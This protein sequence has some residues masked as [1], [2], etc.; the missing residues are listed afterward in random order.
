M[1]AVIDD[2]TFLQHASSSNAPL[3]FQFC[4]YFSYNHQNFGACGG[5]LRGRGC[6]QTRP[7]KLKMQKHFVVFQ[8]PM[9]VASAHMCK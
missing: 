7:A 4:I 6:P 1:P 2:E 3:C 5:Q 9:T 8:I